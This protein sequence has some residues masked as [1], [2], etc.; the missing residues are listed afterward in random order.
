MSFR[1]TPDGKPIEFTG[2]AF[3]L[4]RDDWVFIPPIRTR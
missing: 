3:V 2:C 1:K 4:S